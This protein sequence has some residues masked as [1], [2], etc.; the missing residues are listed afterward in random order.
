[1][2]YASQS[3]YMMSGMPYGYG[4]RPGGPISMGAYGG[5]QRP[6]GVMGPMGVHDP[7][8]HDP[9]M[10]GTH[11]HGMAHGHPYGL[12]AYGQPIPPVDPNAAARENSSEESTTS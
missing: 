11:C 5:Y 9:C 10:T 7:C 6:M 4:M 8:M 2:P 3:P 1:M 12:A